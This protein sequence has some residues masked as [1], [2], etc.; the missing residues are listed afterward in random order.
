MRPSIA[1]PT[2]DAPPLYLAASQS[3]HDSVLQL[4]L[5][6][7]ADPNLATLNGRTPLMAAAAK[8]ELAMVQAAAGT[9]SQLQSR[10]G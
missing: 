1:K 6:K 9:E 4:L 8:G 2:A 5:E 10:H 7:G 3:D